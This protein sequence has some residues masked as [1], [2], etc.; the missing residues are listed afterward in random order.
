MSVY[1]TNTASEKL[2]DIDMDLGVN[3]QF[4]SPEVEKV[5]E[6]VRKY[7]F[8]EAR[9]E[10]AK[11]QDPATRKLAESLITGTVQEFSTIEGTFPW[12]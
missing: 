7:Y 3:K 11:I 6:L 10:A 12:E 9:A 2:K 8:N 4:N 1:R 5:R